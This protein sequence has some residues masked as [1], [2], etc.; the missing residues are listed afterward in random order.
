MTKVN[1]K[2]KIPFLF[3]T[4]VYLNFYFLSPLFHLHSKVE[5][6]LIGAENPHLHFVNDHH[7]HE[8]EHESH[9]DHHS[10]EDFSKH[11]HLTDID[12]I[13]FQTVKRIVNFTFP[14]L[15]VEYVSD[16]NTQNYS[17]RLVQFLPKINLKWER[18][19]QSATNVAPPVA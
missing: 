1:N 2:Y 4:I 17:K 16:N 7:H 13:E 18:Y 3:V 15:V 12:S 5:N 8:H 19:V 9:E 6:D 11:D 10:L 14:Q